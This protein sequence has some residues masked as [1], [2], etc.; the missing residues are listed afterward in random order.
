[1]IRWRKYKNYRLEISDGAEVIDVNIYDG[2]LKLAHISFEKGTDDDTIVS[3]VGELL[4]SVPLY[5]KK[6][7]NS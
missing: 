7:R 2:S 4:K 5:S 6:S 1:M 3:D